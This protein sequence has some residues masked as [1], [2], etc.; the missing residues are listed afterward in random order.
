MFEYLKILRKI[1]SI[2]FVLSVAP[3]KNMYHIALCKGNDLHK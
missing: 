2:L 1:L 3:A